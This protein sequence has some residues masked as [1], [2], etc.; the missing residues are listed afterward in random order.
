MEVL[1]ATNCWFLLKHDDRLFV[2]YR[3]SHGVGDSHAI[4]EIERENLESPLWKK[5]LQPLCRNILDS[6]M[7]PEEVTQDLIHTAEYTAWNVRP[8]DM[9]A[10]IEQYREL[11]NHA[12]KEIQKWPKPWAT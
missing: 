2:E 11:E 7:L 6:Q 10:Y 12:W 9:R 1:C 3:I 8:K 5:E 4:C